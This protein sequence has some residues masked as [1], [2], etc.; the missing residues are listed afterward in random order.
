MVRFFRHKRHFPNK[1]SKPYFQSIPF[2][3]KYH[4]MCQ[5]KIKI[6]DSMVLPILCYGCEVWGFHSA[7][8]V[9]RIHLKFL[10]Q[11]LGVRSQTCSNAVYGETGRMPLSV[12]RKVRIFRFWFKIMKKPNSLIYKTLQDQINDKYKDSWA[13][14]VK[15]LLNELGFSY[16]WNNTN[17]TK[18]QLSCVI[19]RVYDQYYQSWYEAYEHQVS[20]QPIL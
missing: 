1:Q 11:I 16:L 14:K 8:D 5:K 3:I 18:L 10:K 7:L 15:Q 13:S 17:V 19:E 4:S 6:F 20:Y 12:I 9:E 2:L